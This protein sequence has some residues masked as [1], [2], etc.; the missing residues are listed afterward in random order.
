MNQS[1]WYQKA[2]LPP[3]WN[4]P[5]VKAFDNP[6]PDDIIQEKPEVAEDSVVLGSKL[7]GAGRLEDG[8]S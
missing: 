8:I 2:D 5:Q 4:E 1:S 6:R 3:Q 7:Q